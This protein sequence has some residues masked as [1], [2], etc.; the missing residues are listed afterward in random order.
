MPVFHV[1]HKGK[2]R[3]TFF[4]PTRHS[5]SLRRLS[6]RA[7]FACQSMLPPHKTLTWSFGRPARPCFCSALP[8]RVPSAILGPSI[9][10]RWH[11]AASPEPPELLAAKSESSHPSTPSPS[12][13][14]AHCPYASALMQTTSRHDHMLRRGA[15]V[16]RR[17]TLG[18]VPIEPRFFSVFLGPCSESSHVFLF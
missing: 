3:E 17:E 16:R 10:P 14:R 1:P 15:H 5:S 2:S 7:H 12:S 11:R 9:L 8:A 13:R 6:V 18:Q 4:S